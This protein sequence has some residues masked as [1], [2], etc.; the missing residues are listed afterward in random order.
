MDRGAVEFTRITSTDSMDEH[1]LKVTTKPKEVT[2]AVC[3]EE[4]EEEKQVKTKYN[5]VLLFG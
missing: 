1:Y 5:F 3:D 4:I 2:L